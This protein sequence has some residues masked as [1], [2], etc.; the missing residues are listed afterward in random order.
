MLILPFAMQ[1]MTVQIL[2]Q[3]LPCPNCYLECSWGAETCF[4]CLEAYFHC[5]SASTFTEYIKA[6]RAFF[7]HNYVRA[8]WPHVSFEKLNV[9]D[10]IVG[11]NQDEP[12]GNCYL[13]GFPCSAP[14]ATRECQVMNYEEFRTSFQSVPFPVDFQAF[15]RLP[16]TQI[17]QLLMRK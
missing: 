5:R 13:Y 15:T 10:R 16:R 8:V 2:D 4:G 17:Q 3:V 7:L 14:C 6:R 1:L 9:G 11:Q 12:C